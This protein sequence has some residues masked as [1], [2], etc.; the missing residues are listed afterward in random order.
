MLACHPTERGGVLHGVLPRQQLAE[1]HFHFPP[2]QLDIR[3]RQ[4]LLDDPFFGNVNGQDLHAFLEILVLIVVD[5]LADHVEPL[6]E[7]SK[8]L[9][10][11]LALKREL[12]HH[13]LA[14]VHVHGGR[15]FRD[16][17][18]HPAAAEDG[19]ESSDETGRFHLADQDVAFQK[20]EGSDT[21]KIDFGRGVLLVK[22]FLSLVQA[23]RPDVLHADPPPTEAPSN[24]SPPGGRATARP[25]GWS[26]PAP[27]RRRY[28]RSGRHSRIAAPSKSP[29]WPP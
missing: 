23:P 18:G 13:L 28:R 20:Q 9:G 27:R 21:E 8:K 26:S 14:V 12:G 19:A 7:A 15:R 25:R 29:V 11:E 17:A 10:P 6:V 3:K 22:E 24:G 1:R 2:D 5:A 4:F 16:D